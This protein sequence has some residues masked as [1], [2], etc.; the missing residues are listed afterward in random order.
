MKPA[1]LKRARI[2][3]IGYIVFS[4]V[5]YVLWGSSLIWFSGKDVD[6][7][8][9]GL[10]M[11]FLQLGPIILLQYDGH[12][13]LGLTIVG[14]HI[15]CLLAYLIRPNIVTCI[16]SFLAIA[17]WFFLGLVGLYMGV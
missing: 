9:F 7:V 13:L 6:I 12:L 10:G 3:L 16:I 8:V 1:I 4:L 5:A 17:A 15:I 14:T 2:I 11:L